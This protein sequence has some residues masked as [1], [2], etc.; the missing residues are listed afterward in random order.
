M[1]KL[2]YFISH[3]Y[4]DSKFFGYKIAEL[5][6]DI[7]SALVGEVLSFLKQNDYRLVYFKIHPENAPLHRAALDNGGFLADQKVIFRMEL[8]N[9]YPTNEQAIVSDTEVITPELLDIVL[10]T[11]IHS[12]YRTDPG[13]GI[14]KF[15]ELYKI[16]IIKSLRK[17]LADEVVLY[18]QDGVV[19][20]YLTL[21]FR[22][23][24]GHISLLGVDSHQQGKGIGKKL[25]GKA[26]NLCL[27]KEYDT[28]DVTTQAA[29]IQACRFYENFGFRIAQ[30]LDIY[31]I[32]L[33]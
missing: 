21:Q 8:T 32:W 28:L 4:W 23:G 29:N 1:A 2:E 10:Q 20:G 30:T 24:N 26:I 33:K 17:E 6:C 5:S 25:L 3:I 13:F 22:R 15:E 7:P 9:R 31:H 19:I 12:R 27:D 18:K 16:W 11:G 14:A